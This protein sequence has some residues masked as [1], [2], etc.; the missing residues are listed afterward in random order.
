[1]ESPP[2]AAVDADVLNAWR[3]RADGLTTPTLKAHYADLIWDLGP[4]ALAGA[5]RE[6]HFARW[7]IDAYR[8]ARG[9]PS[10][11]RLHTFM[12]LRRALGLAIQLDDQALVDAIRAEILQLHGVAL[13]EGELWWQAY[14]ILSEKGKSGLT[15][16]EKAQ[17]VADLETVLAGYADAADPK[18]FDV[19][20]VERTGER[21]IKHYR[22]A[23]Q[24][25][26]EKRIHAIIARAREH[27]ASRAEA[28]AASSVLN[29]SRES[30]RKAGLAG[31]TFDL[32][33]GR[34]Q[35]SLLW[36]IDSF[37]GARAAPGRLALGHAEQDRPA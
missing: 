1:M 14:D 16:A 7:A 17:L 34:L 33:G 19:H 30:Y 13:S 9:V 26:E 3:L 31:Q 5:R 21:L 2:L 29:D 37:H 6:P 35:Q 24:G 23:K 11:Q 28:L 27:H 4:K 12:R 36:Q 10:E 8:A 25:S 32:C 18:R 15:E 22:Q 20:F